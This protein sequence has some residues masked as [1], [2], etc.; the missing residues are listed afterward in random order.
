MPFLTEY[1]PP[2]HYR[3]EGS[4]TGEWVTFSHSL[5]AD[6]S[7]W[8]PQ[9]EALSHRYR[10]LR[11]DQRGH[12]ATAL[13]ANSHPL[14]FGILADDVIALLD[15]LEIDRTHFVGSS[16]GGTTGVVLAARAAGRI[17]RLVVAGS[18][19]WA[20]P[21][22]RAA[23]EQRIA[24]VRSQGLTAL[25][26][27]TVARWFSPT[28]VRD[29]PPGLRRLRAVMN[30]TSPAGYIR[31]AEMLC[32]YDVRTEAESLTCP[33]HYIGGSL[34]PGW[35]EAVEQF[36]SGHSR[37]LT[38]IEGVGHLPNVEDPGGFSGVLLDSLT[39]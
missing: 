1:C 25:V 39:C 7:I 36:T 28:T 35:R 9:V 27:P 34:D 5:F 19:P 21:E 20:P 31:V 2:L 33:V 10:I 29:R 12:G 4:T 37:R 30:T 14:T 38:V 22:A 11:Y 16:I 26:D 18:R 17:G 32:A 13:G 23:W 15:R 6:L 24:T 8:D 3:V